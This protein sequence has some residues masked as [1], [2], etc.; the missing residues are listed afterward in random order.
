MKNKNRRIGL[1]G[2]TRGKEE[3]RDKCRR[4]KKNEKRE[5][6]GKKEKKEKK[7]K[8]RK[9]KERRIKSGNGKGKGK[10]REEGMEEGRGKGGA[11][12]VGGLCKFVCVWWV[13]DGVL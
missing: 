13:R 1:P 10:G 8:E 2:V 7:G 9:G 3:G 12:Q 6:G 4:E 5:R 11:C